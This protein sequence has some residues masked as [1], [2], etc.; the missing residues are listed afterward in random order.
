MIIAARFMTAQLVATNGCL[1]MALV[2]IEAKAEAEHS[3][4]GS[5]NGEFKSSGSR[6]ELQKG[7]INMVYILC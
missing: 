3:A 6:N 5:E 7:I 2:G 4:E 1:W